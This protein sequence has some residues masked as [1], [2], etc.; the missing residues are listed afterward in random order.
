MI[1]TILSHILASL[2]LQKPKY[3]KLITTC[4]WG[5]YAILSM[6]LMLFQESVIY[7][8]LGMFFLQ[9]IFFFLTATGS[10]GEKVFLFLT[11]SNSF[12]ICL[13]INLIVSAIFGAGVLFVISSI[14]IL[15]LLHLFLCKIL[16]PIYRKSRIFFPHGWWKLNVVLVFFLIQFLNQYAFSNVH[17]VLFDFFVFSVIFYSTLILIFNLVKD[18]ATMNKKTFENNELKT[19]A[20]TDSLTGMQNRTAYEKFTKKQLLN[21]RKNPG[22][23]FIFVILDIDGFK[24]INDTK[25]HA[26]GDEILQQVGVAIMKHFEHFKCESF[27]IG[28]D[29]FAILLEETSLPDIEDQI[30]KMNDD[31]RTFSGVTLSHGC[32]KVDLNHSK[33]FDIALKAADEIMYSNK[34]QN[35]KQS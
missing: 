4:V 11:Y 15:I 8:F 10:S 24:Q 20:Y 22:A 6:C 31:L 33:S 12:C 14:A 3:N 28:G 7:G 34:Q 17:F 1:A 35:K 30:K 19:I 29:E 18:A 5:T 16:L 32:S 13:G 9:G 27:R 23:N 26:V 2:Y 21:A 25:G